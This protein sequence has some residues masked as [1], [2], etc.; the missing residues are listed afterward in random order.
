MIAVAR[1][2]SSALAGLLMTSAAAQS[3]EPASEPPFGR[4]DINEDGWLSGNEL[5]GGWL[6]FDVDGD[7]EVDKEEFTR[8]QA[9]ADSAVMAEP[10][11]QAV[12][13]TGNAGAAWLAALPVWAFETRVIDYRDPVRNDLDSSVRGKLE[14]R[15]DGLFDWVN[16]TSG[17]YSFSNF[18]SGRY[19]IEGNK[20]HL[21]VGENLEN[22]HTYAYVVEPPVLTLYGEF[23]DPDDPD[24]SR[25]IWGLTLCG[26]EN[27]EGT[28]AFDE[29]RLRQA[30]AAC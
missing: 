29:R 5:D 24:D 27:P 3:Q 11:N 25:L 26:L 15:P 28:D 18:L 10:P 13:E 21:D 1:L 20:L 7:G 17:S 14:L 16:R 30:Q 4:L 6:R 8:G 2:F 22:T 9:P 12:R 23:G 19:R